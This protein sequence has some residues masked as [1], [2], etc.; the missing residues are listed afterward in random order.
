MGALARTPFTNTYGYVSTT[1]PPSHRCNNSEQYNPPDPNF[2][3]V[4]SRWRGAVVPRQH[5]A[6]QAWPQVKPGLPETLGPGVS[7]RGSNSALAA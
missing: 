7:A 1:D 2:V 5:D 4:Q 6:A 3:T